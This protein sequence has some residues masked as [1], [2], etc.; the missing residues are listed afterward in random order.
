M[1]LK[2]WKE[3]ARKKGRH[4]DRKRERELVIKIAREPDSIKGL[5]TKIVNTKSWTE[6]ERKTKSL[7][8]YLIC[9]NAFDS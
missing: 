2:V 7:C 5:N 1:A 8:R 4:I 3:L 9:E 6:R